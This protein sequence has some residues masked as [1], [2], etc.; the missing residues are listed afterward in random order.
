M[1]TGPGQAGGE[2]A[3]RET[4]FVLFH[5]HD[6]PTLTQ[7]ER[8]IGE[9]DPRLKIENLVA[10]DD[11]LSRS[12]LVQAPE[13]NA[14]LEV[15]YESGDAVSE[16]SV[17]LAKSLQKTLE[18][19]RLA[20]L[21]RADAR[22]D[23]MHFERIEPGAATGLGAFADDLAGDPWAGDDFGGD[24]DGDDF[25]EPDFASEG[26]DPASLITVVEALARLT[27][28]LPID[29]AAGDVLI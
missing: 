25:A 9:A 18:G 16:Q 22:L 17:E 6:R 3:W 13:D 23:I 27:E 5:H 10:D 24:P 4:Y 26:F 8:A 12:L 2:L 20:Q 7:V 28:G 21:F 1:D 14:A 29:P 15:S 19:D 11:G